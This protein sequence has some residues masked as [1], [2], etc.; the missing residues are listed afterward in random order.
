MTVK[1]RPNWQARR[2]NRGPSQH[3]AA[4]S[5]RGQA[6]IEDVLD[7]DATEIIPS[8]AGSKAKSEINGS[9]PQLEHRRRHPGRATQM[10]PMSRHLMIW[11]RRCTTSI[12]PRIDAKA[13]KPFVRRKPPAKRPTHV[14]QIQRTIE[15]GRRRQTEKRRAILDEILAD[16]ATKNPAER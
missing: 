11:S 9:R 1:N 14:R 7:A 5:R 12:R 10:P 4:G 15:D 2:T 6:A 13:T 8:R 16:P 3:R